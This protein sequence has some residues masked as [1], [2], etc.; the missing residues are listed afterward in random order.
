MFDDDELRPGD[1]IERAHF[2]LVVGSLS[3]ELMRFVEAYLGTV[4][5]GLEGRL[6]EYVARVQ[7][8]LS[9]QSGVAV[10]WNE[11]ASERLDLTLSAAHVAAFRLFVS[12]V[13]AR[14]DPRRFE[15]QSA[16]S[17]P[18]TRSM[19]GPASD[20]EDPGA[21]MRLIGSSPIVMYLPNTP[22]FLAS[23]PLEIGVEVGMSFG[24]LA[25]LQAEIN[26][27]AT[28]LGLWIPASS[29][30]N[31]SFDPLKRLETVRDRPEAE[32][33]MAICVLEALAVGSLD[34]RRLG[35]P[36]ILSC[37]LDVIDR[38]AGI[39]AGLPIQVELLLE[40]D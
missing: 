15:I 10:S 27:L 40:G 22:R 8:Y 2:D 38:W 19:S 26:E 13:A 21:H 16:S 30:M 37:P 20:D 25:E 34:A 36:L 9:S 4:E 11:D 24:S 17:D 7:Q 6:R 5:L 18:S 28:A 31:T 3:R 33:A 12:W 35:F 39:E 23:A 1:L 14:R 29:L 32:M